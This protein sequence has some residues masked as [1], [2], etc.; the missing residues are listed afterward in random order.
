MAFH[1]AL[2]VPA[3]DG[4]GDFVADRE[5]EQGRVAG[6]GAHAVADGLLDLLRQL[7]V[8][9]KGDVLF[10]RQSGQYP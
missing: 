8:L 1:A 6:T 3:D 9:Q 5:A 7:F 4:R 2:A 10:P